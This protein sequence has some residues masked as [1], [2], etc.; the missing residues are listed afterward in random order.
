[1][2]PFCIFEGKYPMGEGVAVILAWHGC[3][4][5]QL[6][7]VTVVPRASCL[8]GQLSSGSVVSQCSCLPEQSGKFSSPGNL[9]YCHQGNYVLGQ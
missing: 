7:P 1:M 5:G 6:S 4:L 8:Q 9:G 3:S 2:G